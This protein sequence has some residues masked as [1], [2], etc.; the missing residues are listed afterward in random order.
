VEHLTLLPNANQIALLKGIVVGAY[1]LFTGYFGMM[2]WGTL[3][4]LA[5]RAFGCGASRPERERFS[6][7]LMDV[8]HPGRSAALA[9]GV[10][11]VVVLSLSLAQILHD[12]D[13]EAGSILLRCAG[14][15]LVAVFLLDL[16]KRRLKTG[17]GPGAAGFAFGVL[18]AVL[19]AAAGLAIVNAV[20][21]VLHPERWGAVRSPLDIMIHS[22][23]L[24]RYMH[25]LLNSLGMAGAALLVFDLFKERT[26]VENAKR[27]NLLV[28]GFGGGLTIVYAILQPVFLLLNLVTLPVVATS[29]KV[30]GLSFAALAA[31]MLLCRLAYG[32]LR[33]GRTAPWSVAWLCI[34]MLSGVVL[35]GWG[36]QETR[37]NAL[38]EHSAHLA[39]KAAESEVL[40][41]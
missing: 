38:K 36:E 16:C 39:V 41:E 26:G 11:P 32:V 15:V 20:S 33:S 8:A 3:L 1:L 23:V 18:G 37:D 21:L 35:A 10:A 31:A 30:F 12:A 6:V 24:I 27:Y 29:A 7:F 5:V 22:N 25:F 19:L 2:V 34:L 40:A 9:L 13:V 4:S 14:M 17:S 28:L